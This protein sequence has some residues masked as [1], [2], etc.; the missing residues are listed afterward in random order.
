VIGNNERRLRRAL[1]QALGHSHRLVEYKRRV[2][3]ADAWQRSFLLFAL[4]C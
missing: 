2:G 1:R 4:E 3:A